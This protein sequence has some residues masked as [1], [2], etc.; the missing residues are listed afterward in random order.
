[1][2][3]RPSV[4]QN[5]VV[6]HQCEVFTLI[7]FTSDKGRTRIETIGMLLFCALTTTVAVQLIVSLLIV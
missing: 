6:S 7:S 5:P 1:M 2:A 3:S 4:Y